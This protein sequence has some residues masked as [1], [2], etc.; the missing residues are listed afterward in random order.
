[1]PYCRKCGAKLADDA[2]NTDSSS[3]GLLAINLGLRNEAAA[4]ISAAENGR[5]A[6][7]QENGFSGTHLPMQS[8]NYP[9]QSNFILNL[10]NARGATNIN[11]NY[12]FTN[13]RS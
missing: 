6:H 5:G 12:E 9:A 7:V 3:A 1:M 8:N 4:S 11:A 2:I 13:T 10:Q